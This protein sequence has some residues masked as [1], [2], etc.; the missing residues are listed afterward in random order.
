MTKELWFGRWVAFI[1]FHKPKHFQFGFLF[2]RHEY[3]INLI[4]VSFGIWR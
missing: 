1:M 2:S 3:A 4:F